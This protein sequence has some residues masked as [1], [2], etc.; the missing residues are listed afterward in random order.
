MMKLINMIALVAAVAISANAGA[1]P[2][3]LKLKKELMSSWKA[4]SKASQAATKGITDKEL[5]KWMDTDKDFIL[6]DVREPNEVAAGQIIALDF[7]AIPRGMVAPAVGKTGALKPTDTVVFYCK[8]G[9]RSAMVAKEIAEAFGYKN[10]YYLKGGITKWLKNG[11][12]VHGKLGELVIS[13]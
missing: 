7:K 10:L 11:H 5:I 6:V 9:S 2:E 3:E 8:L 1:T 4:Y 13:K 12:E